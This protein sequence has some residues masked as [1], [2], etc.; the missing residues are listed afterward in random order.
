MRAKVTELSPSETLGLY[1]LLRRREEELDEAMVAL[2][3]RL[4]RYL[5]DRLSI[6][7]IERIETM[8]E[9]EIEVLLQNL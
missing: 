4:E 8:Y 9:D 3:D 2:F 1:I 6:E 7:Q 5:Y